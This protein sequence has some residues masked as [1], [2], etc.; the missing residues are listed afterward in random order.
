MLQL[1]GW[2]CGNKKLGV[3]IITIDSSNKM[4][5]WRDV[6]DLCYGEKLADVDLITRFARLQKYINGLPYNNPI[7]FIEQQPPAS[8]L[9]S[10]NTAIE[11]ALITLHLQ[12]TTYRVNG[13]MKEKITIT[14]ENIIIDTKHKKRTYNERKKASIANVNNFYVLTNQIPDQH[15]KSPDVADSTMTILAYIFLS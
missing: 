7:V 2:D 8:R 12:Y 6:H 10:A 13:S 9:T 11:M 15:M 14:N 4:T 3:T 1:V 5:I